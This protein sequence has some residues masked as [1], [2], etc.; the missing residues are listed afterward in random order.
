MY[1]PA[2]TLLFTSA[3]ALVTMAPGV[4]P[5]N[6]PA[7]YC[8][9][10]AVVNTN[11]GLEFGTSLVTTAGSITIAPN[12]NYQTTGGV[13]Q[14]GGIISPASFDITGCADN[15]F[16]IVLPDSATLS[17]A[18]SSMMVDNFSSDLEASG[19]LDA[20]GLATM[21]V[22][23]RLNISAAQAPGA[24]SGSFVVEAIFQ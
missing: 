11:T 9:N 23:A 5:P 22:G 2:I 20:S 14:A 21:S 19:V 13:I 1:R 18:T 24:Y 17:S 15:T 8:R 12:G 3:V 16:V 10:N 6:P 7:G 4:G